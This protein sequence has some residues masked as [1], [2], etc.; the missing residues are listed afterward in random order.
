ML[1][2]ISRHEMLDFHDGYHVDPLLS[3]G[4]GVCLMVYDCSG[5]FLSYDREMIF[6]FSHSLSSALA[7]FFL[8][9]CFNSETL[10]L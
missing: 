5:C 7:I 6:R 2:G 4:Y 9:F 3:Y 1:N 10:R 8:I